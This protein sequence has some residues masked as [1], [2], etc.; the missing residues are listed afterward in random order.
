MK[1]HRLSKDVVPQRYTLRLAPDL[2]GFTFDGEETIALILKKPTSSITLHAADLKI[3]T[4]LYVV[5]ATKYTVKK[6]AY[7]AK[8]ETVTMQFGRLPKGR[9]K[10]YLTFAGTL[11][12]EMRGFYR[13][14][15]TH[16]GTEKYLA[17]TQFESIDARRAFPCID[18]PAHKAIFDVS[19]VVPSHLTTVSNTIEKSVENLGDGR[20]VVHYAPS[21]KMSTYLAAFIVGELETIEGKTKDGTRV[22]VYTTP[23]KSHQAEF[24]LKTAIRCLEFHNRYFRIPYPLPVLDMVAVPDF[25]AGAMENWGAITYRETALLVD[26]DHSSTA[27]RQRAAVVIAH[28]IAHQWFGNLA[29]MDWWTDLWLNEGFASYM[30][31]VTIDHLFPE[32]DM[33][34]QFAHEDLNLAL[35][36]DALKHTHPIEAPIDHPHEIES[37]FDEVSYSKGASVIR[38]LATYLGDTAFRKGLH[39]YLTKHAYGNAVTRDLWYAF[40]KASGKPVRAIMRAWTE[41]GGHPLVSVTESGKDLILTQSRFFSNAQSRKGMPLGRWCIPVSTINNAGKRVSVMLAQRSRTVPRPKG[42]WIKVNAGESGFYRT[43]YSAGMRAALMEPIRTKRLAALDRIGLVR[44]AFALAHA[45]EGSAVEAL[46]LAQT[47]RQE[48]DYA[49][50]VELISNLNEVRN[51]LTGEACLSAFESYYRDLLT[52]VA[53]RVGWKAK[54]GERHTACLLRSLILG[55]LIS[56]KDP[57][58]IKRGRT[59]YKSKRIPADLRMVA[60]RAVAIAGGEREHAAFIKAYRKETLSE[61]KNRLGY[62]LASFRSSALIKKTLDFALSKDVRSQDAW[63]LLAVVFANPLGKTVVW[64]YMKKH[65]RSLTARYPVEGKTLSRLIK[66]ASSLTSTNSARDFARFFKTRNAPSLKRA[67]AQTQETIDGNVLWKE[68]EVSAVSAWLTS[69]T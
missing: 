52:K 2:V 25:S 61:E 3:H 9:G 53:T 7:N 8:A 33:W 58:A 23:G 48:T 6:I 1:S 55:Q 4:A 18:E 24:A 40:E 28:E 57:S 19:L 51:L 34:T 15:Y 37:N 10:L 27:T 66:S 13:S 54:K 12:D 20:K 67:V 46:E 35:R 36:L 29:T 31:Y 22:R 44:D 47:Y 32:W 14:R 64:E 56:L 11:N 21:P 43:H 26:P 68:R 59:L 41:E 39:N 38:M 42:S 60:Y 16:N 65:W 45:G 50:W 63:M 62:A 5:G 17:T 69:K 49:V 30:E